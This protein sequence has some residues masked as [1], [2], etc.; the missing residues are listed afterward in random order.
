M[1]V[2]LYGINFYPELTGIGKYSGEMAVWLAAQGH[3]VDVVTA[4]PYYPQW[5]VGEGYSAWW[6]RL[7]SCPETGERLRVL[8]C[9]L[10][11]PGTVNGITR[12]LHLGSF[13]ISS[14]FGL[15]W[16]LARRPDVM[17]VVIPTLFQT[18]HSLL[19]AKLAGVPAWL[20][21][22]D[23]EVDAALD[24]G[25]IGASGGR[26]VGLVKS[27]ALKIESFLMR[28]FDRVSSISHAMVERL[29]H[30]GVAPERVIEFPNWVDVS[31]IHPIQ[32]RQSMRH[33]LGIADDVTVVMY[34]GNMGEKQGLD[35]LIDAAR[36]LRRAPSIQFILAGS[37]SAEERLKAGAADLPNVVWLPLQ[38]KE[39]LNAF[40]GTADIH[41]LPQRA[42]AAD[43]VMPSKLTGMLSSGRAV[44]GTAH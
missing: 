11:I 37:G 31:D 29:L 35:V 16:G 8:R 25:L 36:L 20:H 27:V 30:K 19:L 21:V 4:P 15:M 23:F 14:F 28:R 3:E 34:S 22:Q 40:L 12:L 18:P 42:D 32:P 39:K 6:Y 10:W 43:L 7:E 1:K 2:L 33:E 44:I 26:K 41:I 24:M 5:Q 13:A 38:P 17:L 9:P